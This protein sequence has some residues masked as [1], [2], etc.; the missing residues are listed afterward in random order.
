METARL[1]GKT[2]IRLWLLQRRSARLPLP[3]IT[4]IKA[5]L[6]A[7]DHDAGEQDSS[8]AWR[9]RMVDTGLALARAGGMQAVSIPAV[10]RRMRLDAYHVEAAMGSLRALQSAVA[11]EL[12]EELT[13]RL[14]TPGLTGLA[15][16]RAVFLN[17][18]DHLLN[19][20]G[21]P[22][23]GHDACS[24]E[25][26]RYCDAIGA[27]WRHALVNAVGG[28]RLTGQMAQVDS[29]RALAEQLLAELRDL[30]AHAATMG[31]PTARALASQRF[32][33]WLACQR[34]ERAPAPRRETI[35]PAPGFRW[36]DW[37]MQG[38]ASSESQ[39]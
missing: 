20:P 16:L 37:L 13:A 33:T 38:A 21:I 34:V 26:Q 24:R 18:A 4:E 5:R 8:R 12:R 7:L 25:L 27:R 23:D 15:A 17:G 36:P 28:A 32:D 11:A 30:R 3:P 10:A 2:A 35:R 6:R 39:S 1:A 14:R 29:A 31:S 19:H 9:Q 22:L